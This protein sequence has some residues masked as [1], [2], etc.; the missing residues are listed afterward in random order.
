MSCIPLSLSVLVGVTGIVA[1]QQDPVAVAPKK[2][3]SIAAG[4]PVEPLAGE[5]RLRN[6]R[7]LTFEGENAEAYWSNDGTRLILQRRAG[8]MPADQIYTL[9]LA[10][11]DLKLVSTGTGR[12]TCSYFLKG[13]QKIVFAS[14]H[15]TGKEPPPVAKVER[16]RGYVWSVHREYDLFVANPDG[17]DAVQLTKEAG[18]DAEAT[19]CPVTGTLVFTSVRDGDL[20]LYTMEPDGS[21][22]RR[23]TTRPGYD[24][25]AFFSHDG[26]KLVLR[27]AFPV[28]DKQASEDKELL[29]QAMVRP[30]HMEIT[31][32]RRD[33]SDFRQVTSN[34][35]A[36][37][38]PYWLPDDKRII[39]S[40]NFLGMEEAKKTGDH[41]LARNFD[42]F[43]IGE[44][45]TGLERITHCPEFDGF[46][47]FSPDGRHLVFA[48]NRYG[49]Q[50]G[51]TNLFVAEWVE[52]P[53]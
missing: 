16:G 45:G 46:P 6:V 48:S 1:A 32:C 53:K 19:V 26:S 27:S 40:S 38:G 42:L 28:D 5:T 15:L 29:G 12:T 21:D 35:A 43:V 37:F 8:E 7:Q 30:S 34:G 50:R 11:G 24:G 47:M 33:G 51:E 41:A 18:Y 52:Q 23:I 4:K 44:D 22:V 31:I 9:D 14:T 13:D 3:F 36:N 10:T 2:P 49:K 20:D 39:F 25:G 17:S